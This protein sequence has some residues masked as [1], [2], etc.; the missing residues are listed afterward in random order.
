MGTGIGGTDGDPLAHTIDNECVARSRNLAGTWKAW[1]LD[2]SSGC[3]LER[4]QHK[5]TSELRHQIARSDHRLKLREISR[6]AKADNILFAVQG[7]DARL[8]EVVTT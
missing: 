6:S 7:D 4:R 2:L 5:W 1:N 8:S 3:S